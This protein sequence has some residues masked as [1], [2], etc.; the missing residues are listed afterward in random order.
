M[1]QD[2][3]KAINDC[4]C[5]GYDALYECTVTGGIAT[6][7]KGTAFNCQSAGNEI[8]LLHNTNFTS[9]RAESCN[10]GA[11][12]GYI[13]KAENGTYTSQLIVSIRPEMNGS[14][15]VCANDTGVNTSVIDSKWLTITNGG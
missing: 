9:L 15:I 4:T 7:W 5:P 2:L 8:V 13:I 14:T 11:I 3:L 10:S 1:S 6:V 12:T